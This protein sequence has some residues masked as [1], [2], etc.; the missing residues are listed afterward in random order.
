VSLWVAGS[1][2]SLAVSSR[3]SGLDGS[4]RCLG[5]QGARKRVG[6]CRSA[7]LGRA[8]SCAGARRWPA[9]GL[10]QTQR[11]DRHGSGL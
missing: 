1:R 5:A 6:A 11:S 4:V 2:R 8:C 10:R 3:S 9:A 7:S